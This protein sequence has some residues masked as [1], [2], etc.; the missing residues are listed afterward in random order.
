LLKINGYF[1]ETKKSPLRW[2]SEKTMS[3]LTRLVNDYSLSLQLIDGKILLK[4][5]LDLIPQ[6]IDEISP[7]LFKITTSSNKDYFLSCTQFPVTTK[8]MQDSLSTFLKD[9][10]NVAPMGRINLDF[11]PPETLNKKAEKNGTKIAAMMVL[12]GEDLEIIKSSQREYLSLL[13][14]LFTNRSKQELLG[15]FLQRQQIQENFGKIILSQGPHYSPFLSTDLLD[16]YSFIELT[17]D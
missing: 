17:S 10:F 1:I 5:L 16:F 3:A 4:S 15:T 7:I 11:V 13:R 2:R 6:Q 9:I 14:M 8:E 12:L